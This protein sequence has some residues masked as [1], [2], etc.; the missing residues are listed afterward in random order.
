M[1][2]SI[3]GPMLEKFKRWDKELLEK[4]QKFGASETP[5]DDFAEALLDHGFKN[6]GNIIEGKITRI[7]DSHDKASKKT[8]WYVYHEFDDTYNDGHVIGCA[9][10]GTWRDDVTHQWMS[11]N[12]EY[13]TLVERDDLKERRKIAEKERKA[14]ELQRQQEAAADC[15]AIY[16]QAAQPDPAHG[17]LAT[18]Q[19]EP[20]GY[21]KQHNDRLVIPMMDTESR[22]TSLQF[23]KPNGE[24]RYHAGGKIK[25]S[26]FAIEG[27]LDKVYIVEG[28]STGA[29]IHM[30]TGC[31]V[32]CAFM[33]SNLYEVACIAIKNHPEAEII[34]AGDDDAYIDKNVGKNA[35]REVCSTLRISSRFPE[36]ASADGKPTDWNDL[37]C[38]EGLDQ[39]K[40]QIF[41]SEW[42]TP[43]II[44][45][46][47]PNVMSIDPDSMLP[48]PLS[49]WVKDSAHRMGC[50]PD[51]IAATLILSLSTVIGASCVVK[52]K[53]YDDWTIVPNLWGMIVGSPSQ[54]KSPAIAAGLKPLEHLVS[55]EKEKYDKELDEY[56]KEESIREARKKAL[57]DAINKAARDEL[58]PKVKNNKY[59][60]NEC[61]EP[62]DDDEALQNPKNTD[63]II[64]NDVFSQ[65]PEEL[66]KQ[67]NEFE[68]NEPRA[69]IH[70]RYKSNDATIEML[71]Q[72][73]QDN[74]KGLLV[75]RDELI[76]QISSWDKKGNE[77]DRPFFL[78]AWNGSN[79]F[80]TDRI[81]RGSIHIPNL[82]LCLFGG[83]QP[84]KL[85]AFLEKTSDALS[86]DGAIQRFQVMVYPDPVEFKW[87]D[88]V[89]NIKAK[90][91][92]IKIFEELSDFDP[93]KLGATIDDF[94]KIPYF[95]FSDDAQE[96][97]IHWTG[98]LHTVKIAKEQNPL[99][100][101]HL[102][103]FDKLYSS[104]ALIFHLVMTVCNI[105]SN[106]ISKDAALYAER[107]CVYLESHARRCYALLDDDGA[108]AA[109]LLATKIKDKK[110][111]DGFKANDIKRKNW[112]HLNTPNLISLALNHL[113]CNGW[114]KSQEIPTTV[115]G[116]RPTI[117]YFINPRIFL[118]K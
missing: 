77:A 30:A 97:F 95:R 17:Y 34:I 22:I 21:I 23:I 29:S 5:R 13:M 111:S 76:G 26:F 25:C 43:K 56:E 84:D 83:T 11:R 39:V 31:A 60:N 98:V 20:C 9:S 50:P 10:F 89:P 107:W 82:C 118:R 85:K 32:Y 66:Q 37:H 99:I 51:Y 19:I 106:G 88:K 81:G 28:Y 92:V 24:K 67:L 105:K 96:Y 93:I 12:V 41:Q 103:K 112:R 69:P 71:G 2:L 61:D 54:K 15:F 116:G 86:N 115:K 64:G 72:L 55:I 59:I 110:L 94:A 80:N 18:K 1:V 109:Q 63:T 100:E 102:A 79:S 57:K 58:K 62:N 73:L 104:L 16:D 114:I 101:Q 44:K 48:A 46:D 40:E 33:W 38:R 8:G 52:P 87:V 35:A 47:L 70:R 49:V 14:E 75:N 27:T 68:A 45:V 90:E 113:E 65:T 4:K 3:E 53:K 42:Q 108:R 74:T 6:I 36:F 78:E 7:A 91:Q 117:S